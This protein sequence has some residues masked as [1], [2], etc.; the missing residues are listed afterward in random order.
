MR[1]TLCWDLEL[2]C[3]SGSP[4]FCPF[5]YLGPL[6]LLLAPAVL[7]GLLAAGTPPCSAELLPAHSGKEP[8]EPQITSFDTLPDHWLDQGPLE[9]E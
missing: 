3:N 2:I 6:G 7:R 8:S 1:R 5:R 9:L 4:G